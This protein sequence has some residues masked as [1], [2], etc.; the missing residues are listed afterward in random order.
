MWK[1]DKTRLCPFVYDPCRM[2]ERRRI[3]L[4]P[5]PIR[6]RSWLAGIG[7][8]AL[9]RSAAHFARIA[10]IAIVV[11]AHLIEFY[12]TFAVMTCA[13]S[14]GP[15]KA[16]VV[17]R[18]WI[19]SLQTSIHASRVTGCAACAAITCV[20]RSIALGPSSATRL[21]WIATGLAGTIAIE[22]IRRTGASAAGFAR[23]AT[24]H[25]DCTIANA[26]ITSA[27]GAT[28]LALCTT[29]YTR[30]TAAETIHASIARAARF[31]Y[32]AA[33]DARRAI[34]DKSRIANT[35]RAT[36]GSIRS[37]RYRP[38]VRRN[39]RGQTNDFFGQQCFRHPAIPTA[40]FDVHK[41]RITSGFP[42]SGPRLGRTRIRRFPRI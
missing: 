13:S 23:I 31:A 10:T 24:T 18:C 7:G 14:V 28:R 37:T 4:A 16:I 29:I 5:L 38:S 40:N 35:A 11:D 20:T 33:T 8:F 42:A 19:G 17:V 3:L 1:S 30:T 12:S 2:A 22:S 32:C 41:R 25:A 9:V 15:T 39:A 27:A 21:L 26:L 36:C 6:C 34:A